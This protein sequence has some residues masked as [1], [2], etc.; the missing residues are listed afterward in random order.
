MR[1]NVIGFALGVWL[2]QTQSDLPALG[3][4]GGAPALALIAVWSFEPHK[5]VTRVAVRALAFMLCFACGFVW[6]WWLAAARVA[7]E[8]PQV[9]EARDLEI[10]GVV[11]TLPQPY[12]RSLRFEFDVERVLTPEASVPSHIALSWWGSPARDERPATLPELRPGERWLLSVR[13]RRPHGS[14]NPHG[15]DYE[16]WLFERNI[17]AIGYVRPRAGS[18]RIADF[19][20]RPAYAIERLRLTIRDGM[21]KA[22]PD[23]PYAGVLSALVIGDQRAISQEQWQVF[24][25]TG[26]NHL[27]SSA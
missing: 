23:A 14:L 25:R 5:A 24:T 12:Q 15:F 20:M 6:A 4:L 27:M 7:E 11:A 3:W 17:R 21:E 22:L 18:R 13:L 19:V 26:V 9:W 2:L 16:A 8:L 10:V 1:L